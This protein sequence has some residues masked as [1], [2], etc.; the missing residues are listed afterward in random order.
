MKD[1][2]QPSFPATIPSALRKSRQKATFVGT[3]GE[4]ASKVFGCKSYGVH[5]T[6]HHGVL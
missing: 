1:V 5:T 6:W 4:A 2:Y 3:L